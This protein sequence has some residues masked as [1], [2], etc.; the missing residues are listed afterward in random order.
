LS[1]H[2]CTWLLA[3]AQVPQLETTFDD[4]R[5]ASPVTARVTPSKVRVVPTNW[6]DHAA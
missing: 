1:V 2:A 3:L 5:P 6:V 4:L